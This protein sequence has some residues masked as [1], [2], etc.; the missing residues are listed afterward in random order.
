MD[1]RLRLLAVARGDEPADVVLTGGRVVNVFTGEVEEVEVALCGSRIAGVGAYGMYGGAETVELD[2]AMVGPGLIDAHVHIESSLC[3]PGEFARAVLPRGVTTAVTDPHELA[4]VVGVAG[5][6]WMAGEG[7]EGVGMNVVVMGPCCVPATGLAT[8][9]G[10]VDAG[11]LQRLFDGGVIHGLAEAMDFPSVIGGGDAMRAKLAAAGDR[12]VDGHCPGVTNRALNAYVAAGVG[13]DH[14]AV[15]AAEARE[16]LRRGMYLLIREATNARNLD[17]LLGVVTPQNARRVCFCT[18]D[19]TPGDLL[20]EGSVDMMVRRAIAKGIE[21]VEALR[22]ATL[23]PSEWFG[24]RDV[25][26]IAPGRFADLMVFEDWERFEAREVWYRGRRVARGGAMVETGARSGVD[27]PRGRCEVDVE[28]VSLAVKAEPGRKLRVIRHVA[29][30]LYTGALEVEPTVVGGEVVADVAR[31]V[32]KMAVLERHGK[33]GNVGVGFIQGFGLR[34][35]AI[36]GTVAHDHHNLIVIGAD[37]ASIR[38]AIRAVAAMGG[39]LACCDGERVLAELALPVGGLMS[40]RPVAEVAAGYDAVVAAARD[41]E[42]GLGSVLEDPF[43]AMSFMGLEV[44]PA[45]K[46]TDRGLVDVE[47]FGLVG[48]WV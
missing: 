10:E 15:T 16:K 35:G 29:D 25:G 36:A 17:A 33:N 12:P 24:L 40:D 28:G 42:R 27:V 46:L 22:M 2:G 8:A 13:S 23:N 43:M 5:V 37:D 6:W 19:R 4:N 34:R 11:D 18:D 48:L 14:E 44:I 1:E 20:R 47:R 30:Q 9:G 39:G 21:P 7:K 38:A 32:L 41:G 31:D 3:L 45:L 26:A